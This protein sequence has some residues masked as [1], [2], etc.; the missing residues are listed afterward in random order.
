[1]RGLFIVVPPWVGPPWADR[2]CKLLL[3][4]VG[5]ERFRRSAQAFPFVRAAS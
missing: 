1:M 5:V 3:A 2:V 4:Q